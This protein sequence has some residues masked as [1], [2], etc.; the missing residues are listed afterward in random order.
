[1]TFPPSAQLRQ[2]ASR[3]HFMPW[4]HGLQLALQA[5]VVLGLA[6]LCLSILAWLTL[7]WGILPHIEDWRPAIERHAS[8]A[9]G[10][11]VR[12]G[13]IAV[14]SSGWI[15][16]L[17]MRD[18]VLYDPSG[19]EALRL[20]RVAAALSPRSFVVMAPRLAQLYIEDAR[21]VVRRD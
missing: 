3:L 13:H 17:E 9:I 8:R 1:M 19:A 6:A 7:Q 5:T 14:R 11:P 16:A 21:L 10:V 20:P 4:R 12:I 2:V 15:P 18:V